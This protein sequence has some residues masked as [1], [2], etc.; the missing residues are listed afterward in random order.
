M[1]NGCVGTS[2]HRSACPNPGSRQNYGAGPAGYRD[3]CGGAVGRQ[4]RHGQRLEGRLLARVRILW[5]LQANHQAIART[6]PGIAIGR[7][8]IQN[9]ARYWRVLLVLLCADGQNIFLLYRDALV[10]HS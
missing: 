7:E 3:D 1:Q 4:C 9:N 6:I 5:R 2:H 10:G 8:Q